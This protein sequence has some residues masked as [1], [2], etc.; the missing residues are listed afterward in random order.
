VRV[1]AGPFQIANGL[2]QRRRLLRRPHIAPAALILCAELT[3]RRHQL[4]ELLFELSSHLTLTFLY[5]ALVGGGRLLKSSLGHLSAA[6]RIREH[7]AEK[8]RSECK[9]RFHTNL[10]YG[11]EIGPTI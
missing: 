5:H 4:V 1:E 3:Q 6:N 11:C 2:F 8:Q 10:P 9:E 7:L